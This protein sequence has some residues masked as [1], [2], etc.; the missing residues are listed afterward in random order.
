[1]AGRV[2]VTGGTGLVS[3]DV[4]A[5]L[6]GDGYEVVCLSRRPPA[7]GVAWV[8]ADLAADPGPVLA[9]LPAVDFVVHAAAYADEI[10]KAGLV[11]AAVGLVIGLLRPVKR[12]G[13]G[14][15][16]RKRAA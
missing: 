11:G 2:L 10:R 15:G 14:S 4:L 3:P 12:A 7:A 13:H 9:A 8:E 6:A 1:M 5:R 16:Q